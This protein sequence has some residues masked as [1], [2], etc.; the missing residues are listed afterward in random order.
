MQ[1]CLTNT[2]VLKQTIVVVLFKVFEIVVHY[3]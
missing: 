1:L 3:V 2:S